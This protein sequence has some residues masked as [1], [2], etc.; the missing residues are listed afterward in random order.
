MDNETLKLL[1]ERDNL[2]QKLQTN[3]ERSLPRRGSISESSNDRRQ[4]P[5][6][7]NLHKN[8]MIGIVFMWLLAT[9]IPASY[10]VDIGRNPEYGYIKAIELQR[11]YSGKISAQ[12]ALPEDA[13]DEEKGNAQ[14]AVDEARNNLEDFYF[15]VSQY[16]SRGKPANEAANFEEKECVTFEKWFMQ[17]GVYVLVGNV[18][19]LLILLGSTILTYRNAGAGKSTVGLLFTSFICVIAVGLYISLAILFGT[20][21]TRIREDQESKDLDDSQRNA[22]YKKHEIITTTTA[23]TSDA[24]LLL[25]PKAQLVLGTSWVIVTVVVAM[26]MIFHIN[27]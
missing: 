15:E 25:H 11:E 20:V 26:T 5:S 17:C 3:R 10:L 7:S 6:Q 27:S 22:K 9:V 21:L 23:C 1:I 12:N 18:V 4:Q 13:T 2:D 16:E 14:A 24:L 19:G 8:I